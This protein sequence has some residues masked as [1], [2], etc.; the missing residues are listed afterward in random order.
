M[1][2]FLWVKRTKADRDRWHVCS[3]GGCPWSLSSAFNQNILQYQKYLTKFEEY[4]LMITENN[5]IIFG[6]TF[7]R[8]R[9]KAIG[10]NP[11][12]MRMTASCSNRILPDFPIDIVQRIK[13]MFYPFFVIFYSCCSKSFNCG[14]STIENSKEK[15]R[16]L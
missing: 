1:D 6:K 4:G 15:E 7:E 2:F 16:I 3:A 10:S 9:R 14:R 13:R 12:N 11:C 5:R 8:W